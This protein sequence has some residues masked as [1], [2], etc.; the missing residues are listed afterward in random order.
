MLPS[1]PQFIPLTLELKD[2]YNNAVRDY[3]SYS[4]IS[5]TTLHIW[6]NLSEKL[7]VAE[8]NKNLVINYDLPFDNSSSGFCLIGKNN[9][10]ESIQTI[11]FYLSDS[12]KKVELVHVPEFVINHIIH[13]DK[14]N[15]TEE[16][17]YNEYVLD[18]SALSNLEGHT[19][20][21]LRKKINRFIKSTAGKKV[22][23]K[24]LDL[25]LLTV[26]D[27]LLAAIAEWEQNAPDNDPGKTEHQALKK[28]L[29]NAQAFDIKSLAL[30]INDKL[31]GVV[32][33]HRPEGKDSY[34]LHHLK[35]NYE[36]PYIS[37]Y[38]H[39]EFAKM[40]VQDKVP[41]I[42]I[43]MDLGIENLRYHKMRLRPAKFLRKYR[44][45]PSV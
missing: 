32:I 12:Q 5:F 20:Q 23:L 37:D 2:P 44:I 17:D 33:Y 16:L 26:Q 34:V 43:E 24:A 27:Q 39:H 42:N 1:F 7:Q 38:F 40:A 41:D 13:K 15:V 21:L 35:V 10:D 28:T 11:F 18:S 31:H 4:D 19:Y 3:P 45:T 8:L 6:W 9:I 36:T 29:S 25:G 30:Y 22:E 14:V